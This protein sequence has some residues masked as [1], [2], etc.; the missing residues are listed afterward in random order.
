MIYTH[1]L[2][3][4]AKNF[5]QPLSLERNDE[6]NKFTV[7]INLVSYK[8]KG[9]YL[10]KKIT[11]TGFTIE[12]ACADYVRLARGGNLVHAITDQEIEII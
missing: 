2:I 7:F 11:G 5:E 8:D 9:A 1:H 10:R 12:D 6:S 3:N 4:I